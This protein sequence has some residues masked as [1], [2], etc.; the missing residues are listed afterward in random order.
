M[1]LTGAVIR[2]QGVNFAVV[3]VNPHVL[4]N[5]S[6]AAETVAGLIPVF[7]VPVVLMAQDSPGRPS[8]YGRPDLSAFMA[9]VPINAIPWRRYTLN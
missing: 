8:Y 9:Q 7:G 3:V 2:E 6:E 4:S 5:T 1:E